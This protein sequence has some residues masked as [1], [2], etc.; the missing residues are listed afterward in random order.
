MTTAHSLPSASSGAIGTSAGP[1]RRLAHRVEVGEH[2]AG[3]RGAG[4]PPVAVLDAAEVAHGL[5]GADHHRRGGA[6]ERLVLDRARDRHQRALAQ[7][8]RGHRLVAAPRSRRR[9]TAGRWPRRPARARSSAAG[10]DR[11]LLAQRADA[12]QRVDVLVGV[13]PVAGGGA[14][15]LGEAVALL[16]HAD[17]RGGDAGAL[18]DLLDRQ[19]L[20]SVIN[21]PS[22]ARSR[23][24]PRQHVPST[25]SRP[26]G[27]NPRP[28]WVR[29]WRDDPHR[30]PDPILVTG[31]SGYVGGRLISELLRRGRSVRAL[32]RDPAKRRA[33]RPRSTSAAATPS[34]AAACARR[35]RA[36]AP[37]TT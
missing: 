2:D 12:P 32:A 33:S 20:H 5:E 35:S 18:R 30:E 6:G 25:G 19:S 34:A 26:R 8:A 7:P 1:A 17:R 14:R 37:P 11:P 13:H 4:E 10:T 22:T 3:V 21:L 9:S 29:T 36:A 28:A 24:P 15:G 31:A 27:S 23:L 16:P